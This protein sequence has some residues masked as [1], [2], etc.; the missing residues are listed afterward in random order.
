MPNGSKTLLGVGDDIVH[1]YLSHQRH[2]GFEDPENR[3]GEVQIWTYF[4]N[5][6]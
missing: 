6:T 1:I 4:G 3:P 5:K 2:S